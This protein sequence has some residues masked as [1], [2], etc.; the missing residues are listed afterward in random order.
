[1]SE[2]LIAAIVLAA[3][4]GTRM[5]SVLPKVL[6][7]I[8]G[9]P[10]VRHVLAAVEPVAPAE[11]LVVVGPDMDMLRCPTGEKR[12]PEG[13]SRDRRRGR[14]AVGHVD[15]CRTYCCLAATR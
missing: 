6:H 15:A 9:Q 11:T 1:M 10:M 4:K 7:N 3:G 12:Y 2:H 14:V 8:A 13:S 5:K